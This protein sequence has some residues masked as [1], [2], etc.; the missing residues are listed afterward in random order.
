MGGLLRLAPGGD[1]LSEWSAAKKPSEWVEDAA[2]AERGDVG[3]A[4]F[5]PRSRQTNTD[6]QLA[7]VDRSC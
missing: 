6:R 1:R 7:S 2:M 4:T 5:V 3:R